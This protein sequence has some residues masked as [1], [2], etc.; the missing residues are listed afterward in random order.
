MD[1]KQWLEHINTYFFSAHNPFIEA[2]F[3]L[4]VT[5]WGLQQEKTHLNNAW[6]NML[7]STNAL[8]NLHIWST[9]YYTEITKKHKLQPFHDSHQ[10]F[11]T[12]IAHSF[13]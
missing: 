2:N 11:G 6:H 10:S 8:A 4:S 5:I 12:R 13:Q 7:P 1:I 3:L 9:K